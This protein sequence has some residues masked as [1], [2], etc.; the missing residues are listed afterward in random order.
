MSTSNSA[1]NLNGNGTTSDFNELSSNI[2]P[3]GNFSSMSPMSVLLSNSILRV[4]P[5][6]SNNDENYHEFAPTASKQS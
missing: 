4:L 3:N 5:E 6:Y 2:G 1:R